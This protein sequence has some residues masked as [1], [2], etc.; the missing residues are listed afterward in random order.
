M[1]YS[2]YPYVSLNIGNIAVALLMLYI[3][4]RNIIFNPKSAWANPKSIPEWVQ[5]RCTAE[6]V[7]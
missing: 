5:K 4:A 2:L 1:V 6:D 7:Y 3:S